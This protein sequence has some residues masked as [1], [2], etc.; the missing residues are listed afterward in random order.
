MLEMKYSTLAQTGTVIP[1]NPLAAALNNVVD[2]P[3]DGGIV[4]FRQVFLDRHYLAEHPEDVD[5]MH[6][7][8]V[9]IED[10]VGISCNLFSQDLF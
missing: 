2:M 6:R 3:E 5:A 8:N 9:A 4:M 1:T 7:L 10:H